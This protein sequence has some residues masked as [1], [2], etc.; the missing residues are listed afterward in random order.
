MNATS[1]KTA[2]LTVENKSYE[3]PVLSG[4]V[5]PDVIDR[6]KDKNSDVRLMGFGHRVY[7]N[8]DPHAKIMQKNVSRGAQRNGSW[9]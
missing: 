8:Y 5:G 4:T 9:Q 1:T 6:V 3:F 7:K 2:T